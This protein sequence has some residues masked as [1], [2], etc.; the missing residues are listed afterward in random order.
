MSYANPNKNINRWL[1]LVMLDLLEQNTDE[2]LLSLQEGIITLTNLIEP[3][4]V[5]QAFGP[6][7][8]HYQTI[9]DEHESNQ[10]NARPHS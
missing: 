10:S 5:A 6:W 8:D 2:S 3:G 7:I 4:L 9:L 1:Q